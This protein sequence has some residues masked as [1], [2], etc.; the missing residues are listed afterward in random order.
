ITARLLSYR[1]SLTT[2]AART[3]F[4][5]QA[6][7]ALSESFVS[8]SSA[9]DVGVFHVFSTAAGDLANG[10]NSTTNPNILA[11]PSI[12]PDAD[13]QPNGQPDARLTAKTN[14]IASRTAPGGTGIPTTVGFILYPAQTTPVAIVR[15]EELI[16]MR[17]EAKYFTGD[18]PG[19]LTDLN[20]VRS[21]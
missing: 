5:Q 4:Y 9:L 17:A 19:A 8:T 15:N 10:I 16:L 21:T 2:G 12:V 18:Q 14:T 13:K 3:A 6:L 7:S 20:F 11:H 1:G